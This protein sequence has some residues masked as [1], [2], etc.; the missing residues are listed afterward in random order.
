MKIEKIKQ[1]KTKFL[2]K[3]ILY[4]E[5]IDSTQLEA[6]RKIETLDNGSIIIAREQTAGKGTKNRNWYT[7]QASNIAM[8]IVLKPKCS[9]HQL[10][11]FTTIIAKSIQT[12][13]RRIYDY[14]LQIKQPNDLMLHGKKICGILTECS[15]RQEEVQH[16]VI[17]IGFNV[18]ERDFTKEV[19]EIATSLSKEFNKVY[20][21]E[22]IVVAI[23]EELENS[24]TT[25]N[26]F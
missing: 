17:G 4:F 16:I 10:E 11:N 14:E 24:I 5:K 9:I 22:E 13:I 12:A 6:K 18:N 15:S 2:G 25:L 26:M 3:Q 20:K 1:A 7:G 21:I 19:E 23:L 8:T